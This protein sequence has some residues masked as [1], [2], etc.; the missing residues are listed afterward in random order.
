MHENM[1]TQANMVNCKN[2]ENM[3]T[4]E[5]FCICQKAINVFN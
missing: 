1:G 3:D 2:G 4:P 5:K